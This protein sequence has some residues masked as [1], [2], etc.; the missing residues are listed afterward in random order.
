MV[1]S[2][3][4]VFAWRYRIEIIS[5]LDYRHPRA[6]WSAAVATVF[7]IPGSVLVVALGIEQ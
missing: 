3:R 2:H 7:P 4:K 1:S 6:I 5:K